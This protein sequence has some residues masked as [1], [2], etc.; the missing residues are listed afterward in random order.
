M[1]AM[2]IDV[3]RSTPK[4]IGSTK[5]ARLRVNLSLENGHRTLMPP[6]V[7]KSKKM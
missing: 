5:C 3:M 7:S 6:D 2:R 4:I 1:K